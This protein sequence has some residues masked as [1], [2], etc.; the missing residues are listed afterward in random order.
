MARPADLPFTEHFQSLP[1]GVRAKYVAGGCRCM[2][3]RA[4]NSRYETE[5]AAARKRGEGNGLVD[6]APIRAQLRRLSRQGVGYKSVAIA[7]DVSKTVLQNVMTGRKH[8]VRARTVR[9]VLAVTKDAI[10]DRALVPGARAHAML[11]R[12][13]D[14]GFTKTELAR[15]L[16]SKA[17]VPSLQLKARLLT[18]R[19][20]SKVERLYRTVMAEA[21]A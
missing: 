19:S 17:K 16:G 10:A 15:R 6:A 13:L 12:L 2:L 20:A 14:E 8:Q 21:S 5:R 1:C 11:E 7:A 18:A 4:A 3:C 9:R